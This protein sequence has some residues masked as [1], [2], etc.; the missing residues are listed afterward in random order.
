MTGLIQRVFWHYFDVYRVTDAMLNEVD[1]L[2]VRRAR[3][4]GVKL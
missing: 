1:L 2:I 3:E 4:D